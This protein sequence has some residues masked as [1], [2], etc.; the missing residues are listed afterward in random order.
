MV[1]LRPNHGG[2]SSARPLPSLDVVRE[3]MQECALPETGRAAAVGAIAKTIGSAKGFDLS[4]GELKGAVACLDRQL[5]Q[6][7]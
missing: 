7:S 5:F 6:G 2:Y 1:L 4:L 3:V